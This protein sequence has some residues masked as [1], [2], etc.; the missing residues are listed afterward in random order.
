MLTS[1]TPHHY[2][3][4]KSL[5]KSIRISKR[6]FKGARR[7]QAILS[8][9]LVY[10]HRHESNIHKETKLKIAKYLE[11]KGKKVFIEKLMKI[12]GIPI[13]PDICFFDEGKLNI[14]EIECG[15]KRQN[16]IFRNYDIISK[17]A[18]IQMI[19]IKSQDTWKLKNR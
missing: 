18:Y 10:K 13:K 5:S 3:L 17:K 19:R 16:N 4:I 14:I 6:V 12:E 11:Y 2:E 15:D 7:D 8:E 9:F 1:L